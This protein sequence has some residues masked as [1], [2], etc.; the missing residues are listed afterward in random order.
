[1][2]QGGLGFE[3]GEHLAAI[4]TGHQQVEQD[5]I[6]F[7]GYDAFEGFTAIATDGHLVS[8]FAEPAFEQ[9][10]IGF[11]VIGEQEPCGAG[12][13]S[14]RRLRLSLGE[15]LLDVGERFGI[16]IAG[17]AARWSPLAGFAQQV[18]FHEA[19]PGFGRHVDFSEV[20]LE[21]VPARLRALVHQEFAVADD[22]IQAGFE[23]ERVPGRFV[24]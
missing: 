23:I 14:C 20:G 9:L 24:G 13:Q 3:A 4:E 12:G 5:E 21:V 7:A 15:G 1:V 16:R 11:V 19:K 10:A 22:V 8:E 18:V 6:E 2:A 17:D